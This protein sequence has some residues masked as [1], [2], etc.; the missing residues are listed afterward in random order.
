MKAFPP[1]EDL[2]IFA[3]GSLMWRPEFSFEEQRRARVFGYHRA[4]CILSHHYR[5]TPERPGL[6]LGLDRGG[7]CVGQCFRIAAEGAA[8]TMR[9]VRERELVTD[10]YREAV[11]PVRLADGRYVR[12][13]TYVAD[14]NHPQYA[15][16]LPLAELRARVLGGHGVAGPNLDYV[17]NTH[18]HLIALGIRD[19]LLA[20]IAAPEAP[21]PARREPGVPAGP[22][23]G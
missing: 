7:S 12:A 5:G 1:P 17:L 2:W 23:S 15:G 16:A 4:L 9:A 3:Y 18:R 14:R 8:A 20:A 6:V 22:G 21:S 11:A 19:P 13:V 10:V